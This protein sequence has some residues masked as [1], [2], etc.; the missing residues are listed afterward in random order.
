MSLC[1]VGIAAQCERA[2]AEMDA[3]TAALHS[4]HDAA[5]GQAAPSLGGV[6]QAA[7]HAKED[8]DG[9]GPGSVPSD[10]EEKG[11]VNGG[12]PTE[13]DQ[14]APATGRT[15]GA[16]SARCMEDSDDDGCSLAKRHRPSYGRD[17]DDSDGPSP[18]M[19]SDSD[20]E[21]PEVSKPELDGLDPTDCTVCHA[22]F[23]VRGSCVRDPT[24]GW[25]TRQLQCRKRGQMAGPSH[26]FNWVV[27]PEDEP[28]PLT[29]FKAATQGFLRASQACAA[30]AEEAAANQAAIESLT[31]KLPSTKS[32]LETRNARYASVKVGPPPKKKQ[33]KN[34]S[35]HQPPKYIPPCTCPCATPSPL[36]NRRWMWSRRCPRGTL[37]VHVLRCGAVPRMYDCMTV[38]CPV[39]AWA[40]LSRVS[41]CVLH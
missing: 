34:T 38:R 21:D 30:A 15:L 19:V 11:V 36:P 23:T 17:S 35:T 27:G 33:K 9:G 4:A 1:T 6:A 39:P 37:S 24:C 28:S 41:V 20:E 14:P 8:K 40:S 32:K 16:K 12:D 26:A 7:S 18:P 10:A 13:D 5:C 31:K 2:T 25:L 22:A 29:T 3:A